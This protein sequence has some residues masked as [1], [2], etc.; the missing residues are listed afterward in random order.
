M[1]NDDVIGVIVNADDFGID[2]NRTK[3]ILEGFRLGVVTHTTALV[4]MPYFDESVALMK[5]AGHLDQMGLHLNLSEGKALTEPMRKCRFFCDGDGNFT[6][7][8]HHTKRYRLFLPR[9]VHAIVA[10]EVR[11]QME[12]FRELGGVSNH[13]DSHHHVHTDVSV[14]RIVL[15][16]AGEYGFTSFRLSRNLGRN[17]TILKRLYKYWFN[18]AFASGASFWSDYM[19]DYNGFQ[20]CSSVVALGKTVEIM[21][22]PMYGSLK[23]LSMA[24]ELTDSGRPMSSDRSFYDSLRGRVELISPDWK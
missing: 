18:K 20:D 2:E 16:I 12:R 6:Q 10:G 1:R 9:E 7:A 22:H 5:A 19:C 17:L 21:V 3:A 11:A 4:T 14:A 8:F 24:S 13:L 15:P 23:N